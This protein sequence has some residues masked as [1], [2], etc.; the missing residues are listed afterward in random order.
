MARIGLERALVAL[1]CLL[2]SSLLKCR[3]A[4]VVERGEGVGVE[5]EHAREGLL[6]LL[7]VARALETIAEAQVERWR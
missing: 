7:V 2:F 6:G 1:D 5:L 4:Q 3:D